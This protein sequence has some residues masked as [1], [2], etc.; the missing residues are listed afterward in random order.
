MDNNNIIGQNGDAGTVGAVLGVSDVTPAGLTSTVIAPLADNGGTT[1]THEPIAG[2]L[3]VD[4][5]PF[6]CRPNTDQLDRIRPWDGNNDGSE[7]CDV[8][9]VEFRSVTESDLI[10]KDGFDSSIIMRRTLVKN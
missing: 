6:G 2:G 5:V 4:A 7:L 8:G 3:A 1:L 9:A 10:F